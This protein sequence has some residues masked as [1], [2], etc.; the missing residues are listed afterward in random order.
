MDVA[1][2]PGEDRRAELRVEVRDTGIGMAPNVVRNLC[3]PFY[4]AGASIRSKFSGTGL[5]LV[6]SKQF[7]EAMKGTISASSVLGKGSSFRFSIPMP[8]APSGPE[9]IDPDLSPLAGVRVLVID[10]NAAVRAILPLMARVAPD[11]LYP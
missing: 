2:A 1:A 8:A 7:V 9:K 10:P 3:K 11:D 6:I 5:G 4:Q